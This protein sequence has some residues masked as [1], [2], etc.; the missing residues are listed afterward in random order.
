[1]VYT[2]TASVGLTI[3]KPA[4]DVTFEASSLGTEAGRYVPHASEMLPQHIAD[5][6]TESQARAWIRVKSAEWLVRYAMS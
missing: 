6:K 2:L 5:F 3:L 1:V 4:I